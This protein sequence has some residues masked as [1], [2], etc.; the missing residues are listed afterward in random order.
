M[1]LVEDELKQLKDVVSGLDSRI[2]TLEQRAIGSTP[3]ADEVRMVL[4]GPP[5]AGMVLFPLA[6]DFQATLCT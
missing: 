2:K 5:G 6:A 3:I 4:I 1:G